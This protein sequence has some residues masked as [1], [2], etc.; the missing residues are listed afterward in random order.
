[1]LDEQEDVIVDVKYVIDVKFGIL[2]RKFV[3]NTT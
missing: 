1:M 3:R 2:E